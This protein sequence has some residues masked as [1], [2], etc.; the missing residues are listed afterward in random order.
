MQQAAITPHDTLVVSALAVA[1]ALGLTLTTPTVGLQAV[2][3]LLIVLVAVTSVPASLYLLIAS[4][5]LSPEIAVGRMEGRG[6]G[7]RELSLRMDDILLMVIG[8]SWFVKNILYRELALFRETPLNRPIAVYMIVCVV[9]TLIG[10]LTGR[11]K[12][13]SGFL[14]VLKYFE[15]FFIYFMVVNHVRSQRQVVNLIVALLA[16]GLVISLYAIYQIPG[17]QRATAPFEGE[18]GEPNTL[19]GY[20]VFLLAIMAGLALHIKAGPIRLILLTLGGF[21]VLAL[22]ATLSRSSYLAGTVLLLAVGV[23]QWQRPRVLT[24]LLLVAALIPIFAPGNVKQRVG[25]TFFS[26]QYGGE[27]HIGGVALDL[28]TT[29]RLKSWGYIVK[30]WM[31]A[32]VLGRGVTGYAWADAQYVKIIGETGLAGLAAFGFIMYRLWRCARESFL[33]QTDPFAK[34]LAHGFLLGLV[35][36]L[37]HAIGANTFII[38]RIMEPFWLCAGLVVLLPN[39]SAEPEPGPSVQRRL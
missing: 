22:M 12:P 8:L 25:E 17:G 27:A 30:D 4:M 37:A 13:M 31:H 9:A 20:L 39:L 33:S 26:R 21:A 28:S 6:V 15:Y 7:G 14:F 10:A 35:A 3:G 29:E 23:T 1:V 11:V 2:L 36:M 5:L 16:V 24:V 32:P 18:V 38:I 34:G 19:G